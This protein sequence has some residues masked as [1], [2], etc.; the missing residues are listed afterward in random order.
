MQAYE[1]STLRK[2]ES[3]ADLGRDCLGLHHV[4]GNDVSRKENLCLIDDNK[5]IYSTANSVVLQDVNYG[6][7]EYLLALDEFGIGCVTVHPSMYVVLYFHF[8]RFII[9]SFFTGNFLL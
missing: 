4:F 7:K 3:V 1:V 6:T 2:P 5:L 9:F 8:R